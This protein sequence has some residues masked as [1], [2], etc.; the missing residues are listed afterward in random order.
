MGREIVRRSHHLA[1]PHICPVLIGDS[2]VSAFSGLGL[3][4]SRPK[5]IDDVSSQ[6]HT[7]AVL[8]KALASTNVSPPSVPDLYTEAGAYYSCR[9][10]SSTGHLAR[11]RRVRLD[12][13]DCQV[14]QSSRAG[15]ILALARQLF[16]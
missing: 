10:C 8:Q 9:T 13:P 16:G 12:Y 4:L 5:T 11:G 7:V 14:G 1:I 2:H 6:E 3:T 15:T